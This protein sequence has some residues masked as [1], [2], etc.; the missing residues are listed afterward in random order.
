MGQNEGFKNVQPYSFT[1]VAVEPDD[2]VTVVEDTINATNLEIAQMQKKGWA[3]VLLDNVKKAAASQ[4]A[5]MLES[6][7][8]NVI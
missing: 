6:L 4:A 8:S 3:K 7:T 1:C 5:Q 2:A